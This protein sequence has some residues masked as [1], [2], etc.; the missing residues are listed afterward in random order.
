MKEQK[1]KGNY[2]VRKGSGQSSKG[3]RNY[4]VKVGQKGI[5]KCSEGRDR[6]GKK[7]M[8]QGQKGKGNDEAGIERERK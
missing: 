5:G 1:G 7:M 6:K 2:V 3:K 8:K 4:S